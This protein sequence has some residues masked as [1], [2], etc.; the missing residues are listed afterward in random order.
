MMMAT[1][2]HVAGTRGN[3][4]S[5]RPFHLRRRRYSS[6][7][8]HVAAPGFLGVAFFLNCLSPHA[9]SMKVAT[10]I[11]QCNWLKQPVPV[12]ATDCAMWHRSVTPVP[13]HQN[14]QKEH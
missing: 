11:R 14:Q 10:N 5:R 1:R 7:P 2:P 3:E 8:L 13:V 12:P 6:E 4:Q 9:L